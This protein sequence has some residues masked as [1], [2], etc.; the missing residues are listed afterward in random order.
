VSDLPFRI[1]EAYFNIVKGPLF[2]RLGRQTISWGESDTIGLLDASNPFDLTRAIPGIF[3]DL[4]EARIPLWT[5]RGTYSLFESWGPFSSAYLETY[6]V[7]GSIDTTVSQVPLP[8]ASPYSP[9]QTDP[10]S[11][12][13]GLIPPDI[14][15]T[16]VQAAFGGIQIGLYDHLPTRSMRNSRYGV[17]LGSIIARDYTTSVWYYRTFANAPVP[18]FLPL[19]TSRAPIVHPGATGPTQLI[20]EL[21]HGMVDVYGIGTSFFSNFLNGVVRSEAEYFVNEPAFIPSENIPFE[22][23]LRT[24]AVRKLLTGLGQNVPK[25][26]AEGT[27]PRADIL[28]FE[29]GMDR[30][31]FFR[32]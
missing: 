11:L 9:P 6:L 31:F 15:T 30:F 29:L 5:A 18:R 2:L 23:L 16:I 12:L 22:R 1:N 10:Q 7:P 27:I 13:A 14:N 17:R 24:P 25:G 26:L 8:L 21:H 32:P 20:T 4:D 3:Q 19:D 28:R